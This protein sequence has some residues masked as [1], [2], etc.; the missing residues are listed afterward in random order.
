VHEPEPVSQTG[1]VGWF[2]QSASVWQRPQAPLIAQNGLADGQASLAPEPLS[3]LQCAQV[4]V[5]RSHTGVVPVQ[6]PELEAEHC[7][8]APLASQ[9]GT[10]A[11]GQAL[12]ALDP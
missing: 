2:V 7:P 4:F 1:P 5:A 3:P 10:F 9:A 6:R 11:L 12:D 8:Q